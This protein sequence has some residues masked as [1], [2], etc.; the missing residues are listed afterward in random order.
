MP[1]SIPALPPGLTWMTGERDGERIVIRRADEG[2]RDLDG[3]VVDLDALSDLAPAHLV[4]VE[5]EADLNRI[6]VKFGGSSIYI[7]SMD[8][9]SGLVMVDNADAEILCQMVMRVAWSGRR[10]AASS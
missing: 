2:W 9:P 3:N 4:T 8:G 5:E 10:K 7:M 1:T 6:G